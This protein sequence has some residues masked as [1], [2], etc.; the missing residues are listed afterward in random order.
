MVV[1]TVDH[2]NSASLFDQRSML[3][4][5]WVRADATTLAPFTTETNFAASLT[6]ASGAGAGKALLF[7][8]RSLTPH[9]RSVL[10]LL[11][12]RLQTPE[13]RAEGGCDFEALLADALD[14][15]VVGSAASLRTHLVEL[16]DHDLAA[17]RKGTSGAD[18]LCMPGPASRAELLAKGE[19]GIEEL[20]N[21]EGSGKSSGKDSDVGSGTAQSR[22]GGDVSG[23]A[24]G[25]ARGGR[26]RS[27]GRGG[28][29]ASRPVDDESD[30]GNDS[31]SEESDSEAATPSRRD[32][33]SNRAYSG[34]G[35][36]GGS[37]DDDD[38]D[39][40]DRVSGIDK[41]DDG[42]GGDALAMFR[43]DEEAMAE[44]DDAAAMLDLE[45]LL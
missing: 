42:S 32:R 1:V 10:R 25:R 30:S 21:L 3:L 27:G 4:G 12:R 17:Y 20:A 39:D 16:I 18:V 6:A 37:D 35:G 40:D 33:A 9:H 38:D 5:G 36:D 14:E 8:L 45:G 41:G 22:L 34:G 29:R 7:V 19:E 13:G 43:G 11:A 2:I 28:R 26:G 24:A 31:G 23:R 44:L 15:M